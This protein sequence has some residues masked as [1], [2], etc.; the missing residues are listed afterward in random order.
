ML[1]VLRPTP[2]HYG[3]Y[4]TDLELMVSFY[5]RLFGLTITDRGKG[6]TFDTELVFT[7]ASEDQH[8]QLVFATGRPKEATFSTIMQM[9]FL[10][11]SIQHLRDL[12][13]L[14]STLGATKIRSMNHGNALSVYLHDPEGNLVEVYVDLPYYVSQPHGEPLDLSL[15][16]QEILELTEKASQADPSFK[17]MSKWAEDYRST[18]NS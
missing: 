17:T 18:V 8:H 14:A 6:V 2:T 12:S 7:S 15:T 13:A 11:P 5:T 9:S 10:V 1:K 3:I 4:V 16:E